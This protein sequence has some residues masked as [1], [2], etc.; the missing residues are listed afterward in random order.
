MRARGNLFFF[1][2]VKKKIHARPKNDAR[3]NEKQSSFFFLALKKLM[4]DPDE[5]PCINS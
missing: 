3:G 5:K 1:F 4:V 2:E